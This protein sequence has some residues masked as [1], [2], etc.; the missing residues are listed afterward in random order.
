MK[1]TNAKSHRLLLN[2]TPAGRARIQALTLA[3]G[4]ATESALL[5][6]AFD[7]YAMLHPRL[8]A[9]DEVFMRSAD[10]NKGFD[11][12]ISA[13]WDGPTEPSAKETSG[14]RQRMELKLDPAQRE[15]LDRLVE[16]GAAP[17]LTALAGEALTAYGYYI[18]Y[19]DQG[20]LLYLR[21]KDGTETPLT[22]VASVEAAEVSTGAGYRPPQR[23]PV[24]E[25]LRQEA[26][27]DAELIVIDTPFSTCARFPELRD[28]IVRTMRQH[29][30]QRNLTRIEFVKADRAGVDE[31]KKFIDEYLADTLD[32]TAASPE[33]K[34]ALDALISP[35]EGQERVAAEADAVWALARPRVITEETHHQIGRGILGRLFDPPR[36]YAKLRDGTYWGYEFVHY[37]VGTSIADIVMNPMDPE[38]IKT[39]IAMLDQLTPVGWNKAEIITAQ[40]NP[41]KTTGATRGA[42]PVAN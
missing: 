35:L 16:L 36:W 14:I 12:D 8:A 18:R 2:T 22:V 7:F 31:M 4:A 33:Q 24:L 11:L 40:L 42:L 37:E 6:Q 15:Q 9:G 26:E 1:H 13:T 10:G 32:F 29:H 5:R 20:M 41:S 27:L 3:S 17:T 23:V 19:R 34:T 30:F 39:R 38:N 21:S 28:Q 25:V